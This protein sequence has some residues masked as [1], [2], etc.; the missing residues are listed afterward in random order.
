MIDAIKRFTP[1]A[2]KYSGISALARRLTTQWPRIL[3]YH[4]FSAEVSGAMPA[5]GRTSARIFRQQ[6][7]HLQRYYRP[8]RLRELGRQLAD[9]ILPRAGSVAITV[10]DGHANF[11]A[12]ALPVLRELNIPATFFVLSELSNSSD[13]LWSD[14]WEYVRERTPGSSDGGPSL[15]E[16]KHLPA[17]D[18]ERCLDDFARRMGVRIPAR[19]P[20]QYAVVSW[21]ELRALGRSELVDI[22]SHSRTH[23]ILSDTD[24]GEA[25][26]EI[27]GSRRELE[28]RL[29]VEIASFCFPNGLPGDYRAEQLEMVARAGYVCATASHFGYV[30]RAS[31]RFA[32]PRIGGVFGGMPRFR[33]DLDGLEYVWRRVRGELAS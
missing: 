14:K 18:R 8:A 31:N 3:M 12:C 33:Q 29:D 5:P 32:L 10:D 7:I 24:D 28:R 16:L 25:W 19:P 15:S 30:T 21:E 20:E 27:D 26:D 1:A 22:G 17:A 6:M 4:N 2:A 23:R 11:L 13:W 9:G